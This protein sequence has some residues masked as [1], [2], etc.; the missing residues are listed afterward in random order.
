MR[1]TYEIFGFIS[2]IFFEKY[3][4]KWAYFDILVLN[5]M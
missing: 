4:F 1:F 3:T 2:D 5:K